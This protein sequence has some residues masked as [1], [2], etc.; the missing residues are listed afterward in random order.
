MSLYVSWPGAASLPA[1]AATVEFG[2]T[3]VRFRVRGSAGGN[4]NRELYVP[5]LC[6]P[7]DE[8]KSKLLTK[9]DRFVVKVRH[10]AQAGSAGSAGSAAR[11]AARTRASLQHVDVGTP[12]CT[13]LQQV[14]LV[15]ACKSTL[16]CRLGTV[17]LGLHPD[18]PP[19]S[20]VSTAVA[21][22]SARFG[23]S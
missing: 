14:I 10:A 21:R 12:T 5:N 11:R 4:D 8:A 15:P 22:R 3:L 6:G 1:G 17:R 18:Q 20:F 16:P 19:T 9:E 23:A 2:P 13:S 7:I